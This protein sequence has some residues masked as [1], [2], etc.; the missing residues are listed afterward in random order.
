M[1]AAIEPNWPLFGLQIRSQRLVLRLPTDEDLVG[2]IAV[3]RA[4]IHPEG[5]MPFGVAWSTITSPAFE[6]SFLQHQWGM[7]A[8]WSPEAWQLNLLVELDG[9]P[10]G[11][12]SIHARDFAIHGTVDTGSW[13]GRAWQ[14]RGLGTEMRLAILAFAFEGLGARVA[15]SA[16][17]LDNAASNRVSRKVGYEENGR[18]SLAPEGV[19]R[20]TQRFRMTVEGWRSQPRP[21]VEIKGLDACLAQFGVEAGAR[22]G[23]AGERM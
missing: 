14:G 13:I 5:T 17:F 23:S 16:A 18:G 7:R 6:R 3:A 2:L 12:Q 20:E 4:G 8:G 1:T 11:S 19:A 10:I 15:E 9:A 22:T 21:A